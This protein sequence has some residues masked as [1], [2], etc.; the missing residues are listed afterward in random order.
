MDQYEG[1]RQGIDHIAEQQSV[2]SVNLKQL[3]PEQPRQQSL[4]SKR[5][6]DCKSIGQCREQHRK[7]CHPADQFFYDLWYVCI[8]DGIGQEKCHDRCD[9]SA[10]PG[11]LKT[12]SQRPQK[13]SLCQHF[14]IKSKCRAVG[15]DKRFEQQP[16]HRIN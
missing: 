2:E 10:C 16:H 11:N 7:G 9:E 5:V 13:T 8:M 14:F 6:N 12:I 15:S 3:V 4:F 1:N